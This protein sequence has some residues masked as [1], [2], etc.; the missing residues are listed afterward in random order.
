M[1]RK[2]LSSIFGRIENYD[3]IRNH[4]YLRVEGGRKLLTLST[5]LRTQKEIMERGDLL[6]SLICGFSGS[7]MPTRR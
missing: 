1:G 2:K 5:L 7:P 3:L 6:S 4:L